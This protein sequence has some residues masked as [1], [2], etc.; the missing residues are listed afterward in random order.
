[1]EVKEAFHWVLELGKE[2]RPE[3]GMACR[4]V[5][6]ESRWVQE[7]V[8]YRDLQGVESCLGVSHLAYQMEEEG[9]HRLHLG[10]GRVAVGKVVRQGSGLT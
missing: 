5:E 4:L 2:A 7:E 8:A 10:K 9:G 3:E 6:V 1:L